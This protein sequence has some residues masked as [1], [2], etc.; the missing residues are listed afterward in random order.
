MNVYLRML[1]SERFQE[2]QQVVL[3]FHVILDD[4]AVAESELFQ[5]D[6]GN[7]AGSV[8][9][10]AAKV[11]HIA[12]RLHNGTNDPLHLSIYHL[13]ISIGN[14]IRRFWYGSAPGNRQMIVGKPA[15]RLQSARLLRLFRLFPQ[16][17]DCSNAIFSQPTDFFIRK[18][19]RIIA[20]D[21]PQGSRGQRS[22]IPR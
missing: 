7:H 19:P 6:R 13:D 9:S 10:R 20:S 17:N 11:Q 14:R 4:H 21:I 22:R 16:V 12:F 8:F 2:V 1:R 15:F 3:R 5:Q 18:V